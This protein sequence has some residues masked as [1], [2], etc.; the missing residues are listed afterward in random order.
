MF[1]QVQCQLF[2]SNA[3]YCDFVLWTNE[4]IHIERIYPDEEFWLVNVDR[5]KLFFDTSILVELL[6][7]F[8]TR[9]TKPTQYVSAQASCSEL[10]NVQDLD[11]S[12]ENETDSNTVQLYCYCQGPEEGDMVGCDNPSCT[13]QWFH[14][15][16]LKLKSLPQSK[17]WYCPDCKK[18][19][20]L[21]RRKKK[22]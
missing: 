16:C 22:M 3:S 18:L 15:K 2:C 10:S 14:L 4:D 17:L 20:D 8:Y 12:V 13:F 1:D 6:G 19:P 7:K 21:K 9:V 5:A 11:G